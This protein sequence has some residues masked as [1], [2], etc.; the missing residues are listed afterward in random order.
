MINAPS[1]TAI[2]LRGVTQCFVN[3]DE[4]V[5]ALSRLDFGVTKGEF[6]SLVGPTG[7]GKSTCLGLIAGV[8][9]PSRGTVYVE[10]ERVTKPNRRVGYMLQKD[11]LMPWRT[12][13]QN[14]TFGLELRDVPEKEAREIALFYLQRYGLKG[15][16][17]HYPRQ[18]SG[19]MRQRVA[20]IR[21]LVLSPD[22]ILL[23]EPF[24]ALD[25]QTRLTLEEEVHRILRNEG[26]SALLVTHD[27]AEAIAMSDRV[28]VLTRRPGRIKAEHRIDL[29]L[30]G[31]SPL[32]ARQSREFGDY[33]THVWKELEI[34]VDIGAAAD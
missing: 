14:V 13:L 27:I 20:L 33:F 29:T 22:I 3:N 12:V 2:E 7:C 15:F 34:D 19:G 28:L 18:L 21:T 16:D 30:S 17:K 5:V 11:L 31:R 24:S 9:K 32:E 4:V 26:K 8:I 25:F 23:D 1:Q 10:G 6:V